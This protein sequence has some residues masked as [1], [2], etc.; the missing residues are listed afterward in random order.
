L[1]ELEATQ[2]ADVDPD[3][4]VAYRGKQ[5]PDDGSMTAA[6][7]LDD[8]AWLLNAFVQQADQLFTAKI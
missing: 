3:P 2:A 7:R 6:L 4:A 8:D 5:A 1:S